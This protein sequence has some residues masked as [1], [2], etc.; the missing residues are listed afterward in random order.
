MDSV[1]IYLVNPFYSQIIL[2]SQ[3][4]NE[5]TLEFPCQELTTNQ[6]LN[7]TISLTGASLS[8]TANAFPCG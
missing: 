1:Y 7:K 8:S 3:L 4:N 6:L 2:E 5:Q